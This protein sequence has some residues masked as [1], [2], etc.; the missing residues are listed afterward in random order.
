MNAQPVALDCMGGDLGPKVQVEGA[1]SAF[2]KYGIKS[3]L[4]GP[5]NKL[6]SIKDSLGVNDLPLEVVNA[7]EV[8]D[9]TDSPARAVRKKPN[10]SLCVAYMPS[11]C[12]C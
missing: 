6:N 7:T 2:K 1:V 3:I 8:I 11:D 12:V 9:M 4:V 10:S 5:E